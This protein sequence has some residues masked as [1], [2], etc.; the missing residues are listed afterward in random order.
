[1]NYK[2][3]VVVNEMPHVHER[4]KV[5]DDFQKLNIID[6]NENLVIKNDTKWLKGMVFGLI[7]SIPIW[8]LIISFIIWVIP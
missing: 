3:H 1:M 7:F 4:S 6:D 2:T 8:I 5:Y